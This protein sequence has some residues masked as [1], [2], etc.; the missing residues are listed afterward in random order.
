[1]ILYHGTSGGL[2]PSIRTKGLV[3]RRR[4]KSN[5][6]DYP[7]RSD[8]VYLTT[9]YPLWFA[10]Q[11]MDEAELALVLE[12]DGDRLQQGEWFPDEDFVAQCLAGQNDQ[13][14]KEVHLPLVRNLEDYRHHW[15]DSIAGLGNAAY[16]GVIP[17]SAVTRY[18]MVDMAKQ[19]RLHLMCDP[20]ISLM[21]YKFCGDNYR[22]MVAWLF[23]DRPDYPIGHGGNELHFSMMEKYQPDIRQQAA[24]MFA[25]RDGITVTTVD[26]D[27]PVH[28]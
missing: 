19:K 26:L 11:A 28:S 20:T 7:S 23:G 12:I 25:D 17:F 22:E 21:N 13:P 4:R 18:C 8:M 6:K 15:R 27:T 14:L 9:A 3:P 16:R 1:M 2:L 5:W 24:T 10:F